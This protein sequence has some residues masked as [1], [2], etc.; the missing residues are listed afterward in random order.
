MYVV[1]GKVMNAGY[2]V[3]IGVCPPST[4]HFLDQTRVHCDNRGCDT[5]A[6]KERGGCIVCLDRKRAGLGR[7][8]A[9]MATTWIRA[10]SS[11]SRARVMG[12]LVCGALGVPSVT[13]R[14]GMQEPSVFSGHKV[15]YNERRTTVAQK[16]SQQLWL[17]Y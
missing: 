6:T 1:D 2:L 10:S 8:R 7:V 15:I 14:G 11:V 5:L 17:Y 12:V 13:E 9:V 16:H 3:Y 4:I